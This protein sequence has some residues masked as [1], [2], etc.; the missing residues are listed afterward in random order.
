MD[1]VHDLGTFSAAVKKK[2]PSIVIAYIKTPTTLDELHATFLKAFQ[3]KGNVPDDIRI[4]GLEAEASTLHA[5]MSTIPMFEATRIVLVRHSDQ[6]LKKID[7]DKGIRSY[8]ERDIPNLPE[9]THLIFHYEGKKIPAKLKFIEDAALVYEEKPLR[10]QDLPQYLAGKARQAGYQVSMDAMHLLVE[11]SAFDSIKAVSA[12]NRLFLY[13]LHE[14][15]IEEE[16]VRSVCTGMEG[17]LNF[18]ILDLIAERK[19]NKAIEKLQQH[20]LSEGIMILGLWAKLFSDLFR[21]R[22]YANLGFSGKELHDLVG[23]N[24]SH[25]FFFERNEKRMRTAL[26]LYSENELRSIL[27]RLSETDR[28]IKESS[29]DAALQKTALILFLASLARPQ[30][31]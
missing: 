15:K 13:T 25:R 27:A 31:A 8:F 11:K 19:T 9:G 18:A 4:N 3:E 30:V 5:E 10:E 17:D 16:D 28:R 20:K 7:S 26:S 14:K 6:I 2:I 21:Y 24:S 1:K 12:L 29:S 22:Q 23:L